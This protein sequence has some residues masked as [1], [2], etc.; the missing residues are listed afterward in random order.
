[1]ILCINLFITDT[2]IISDCSL[3]AVLDWSWSKFKKIK[4]EINALCI[5]FF[6]K[7]FVALNIHYLKI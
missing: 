3:K 4:N 7:H 5:S 1:M 6:I 2:S